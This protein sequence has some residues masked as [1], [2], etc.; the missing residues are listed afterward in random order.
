MSPRYPLA[1]T[2]RI[3]LAKVRLQFVQELELLDEA[4]DPTNLMS[5]KRYLLPIVIVLLFGSC[6]TII[7]DYDEPCPRCDKRKWSHIGI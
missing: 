2:P 1:L 7:S 5:L 6:E 4:I 3:V